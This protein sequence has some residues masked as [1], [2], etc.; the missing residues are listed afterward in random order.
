MLLDDFLP[1]ASETELRKRM[2]RSGQDTVP[3]VVNCP[4][5]AQNT[6][7]VVSTLLVHL[8]ANEEGE[9]LSEGGDLEVRDYNVTAVVDD[10]DEGLESNGAVVGV[11][12]VAHGLDQ[13]LG[14][15]LGVGEQRVRKGN[16]ECPHEL[17]EEQFQA[18]IVVPIGQIPQHQ[19]QHTVH[20]VLDNRRRALNQH[21]QRLHEVLLMRVVLKIRAQM[22]K[23]IVSVLFEIGRDEDG[24]VHAVESA[25]DAQ[26]PQAD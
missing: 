10:A 6:D 13:V 12:F 11:E 23:T 14:E 3:E 9:G 1:F 7:E 5:S 17:E 16:G 15:V 19:L 24:R 4:Q 18:F 21:Y 22:R 25:H 20:L 2:L 8:A 26:R